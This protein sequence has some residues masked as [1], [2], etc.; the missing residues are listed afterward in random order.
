MTTPWT[1]FREP[2]RTTL[3]RTILIAIVVGAALARLSGAKIHWLLAALLV[4]WPSFGGHWVELWYL[5]WLRPRLSIA[6]HVQ[7]TARVAT[8]FVGGTG[9]KSVV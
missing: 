4:L 6:R 2:L 8:W 9:R 1:P 7:I 3:L 5:N